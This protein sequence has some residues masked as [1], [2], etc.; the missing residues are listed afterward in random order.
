MSETPGQKPDFN[1]LPPMTHGMVDDVL[2]SSEYELTFDARK[3]AEISADDPALRD[4]IDLLT[5]RA[6]PNDLKS[7]ERAIH[8]V[9]VTLEAVKRARLL[10][11]VFDPNE[12]FQV[13]GQDSVVQA[14]TTKP[15]DEPHYSYDLPP[16]AA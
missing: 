7:R 4:L 6:E 9:L 11:I 14:L 2:D 5:A 15:P 8:V 1:L 12:H 10:E 3:W 13:A 16:N